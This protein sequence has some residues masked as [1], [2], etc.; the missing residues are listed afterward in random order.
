MQFDIL[1]KRIR[2][3]FSS[4]H[5][6]AEHALIAPYRH[7]A[8]MLAIAAVA[9]VACIGTGVSLFVM[10]SQERT[11][12]VGTLDQPDRLVDHARLQTLVELAQQR[13]GRY[14]AL[15][16]PLPEPLASPAEEELEEERTEDLP[17]IDA[18]LI[19]PDLIFE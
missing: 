10:V 17:A 1:Q 18:P 5:T 19:D 4:A 2:K 7:W 13:Q 3:L 16:G 8:I 14:E 15:R 9:A 11:V 6:S 12:E